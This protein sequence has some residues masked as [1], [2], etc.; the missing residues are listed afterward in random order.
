MIISNH[1]FYK[2]IHNSGWCEP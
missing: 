2:N 1:P